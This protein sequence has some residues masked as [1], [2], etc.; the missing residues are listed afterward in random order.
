VFYFVAKA[1]KQ[2]APDRWEYSDHWSLDGVPRADQIKLTETQIEK[3]R[4]A[5]A[6][7]SI[8]RALPIFPLVGL[9]GRETGTIDDV[10]FDLHGSR[11]IDP[12]KD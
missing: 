5:S 1:M 11:T 12:T 7:R 9:N 3:P 2:I 4:L 10:R 8:V 6:F